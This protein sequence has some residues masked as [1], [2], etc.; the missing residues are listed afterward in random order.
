MAKTKSVK[1]KKQLFDDDEEFDGQ[2][3]NEEND[4]AEDQKLPSIDQIEEPPMEELASDDVEEDDDG[5]AELEALTIVE[6]EE[7]TPVIADAIADT[8]VDKEDEE[9]EVKSVVTICP[10]CHEEVLDMEICPL[11]G[12]PLKLTADTELLRDTDLDPMA[13]YMDDQDDESF[14]KKKS[15]DLTGLDDDIL[16]NGLTSYNS[17]QYASVINDI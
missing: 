15:T 5:G 6:P 10:H 11:C 1:S 4:E 14:S 17:D 3:V 8:D 12:N 13:D 16:F 7:D 9:E 2:P